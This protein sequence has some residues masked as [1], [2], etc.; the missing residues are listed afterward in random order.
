MIDDLEHDT[1]LLLNHITRNAFL[2]TNIIYMC[3]KS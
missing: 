2:M 1:T 3:N